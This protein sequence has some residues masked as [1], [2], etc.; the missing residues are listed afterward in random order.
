MKDYNTTVRNPHG[1]LKSIFIAAPKYRTVEDWEQN[2][3]NITLSNQSETVQIFECTQD[4]NW[5]LFLMQRDNDLYFLS[6]PKKKNNC[7]PS[8]YGNIRYAEMYNIFLTKEKKDYNFK[9]QLELCE[10]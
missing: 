4:T 1:N 10:K 7:S 8:V 5:N 3:I 2:Y 6:I 9:K